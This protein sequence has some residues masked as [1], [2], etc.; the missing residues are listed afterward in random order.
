M[1]SVTTFRKISIDFFKGH[2]LSLIVAT[3]ITIALLSQINHHVLGSG[4][5]SIESAL[6]SM[7]SDWKTLISLFAFKFI[8][9]TI[10]YGSGISGGLFMP[11]LLLG[12]SL[13]GFIGSISHMIFPEFSPNIGAFALIGMGSFFASVIKAP[14]TSIIMVFELTRDYNIILPLMISNI[15][16]YALSLALDKNSIYESISEQDGIHLP[17][18]EDYEILDTF[19]VEEAM[20]RDVV[21]LQSSD[22]I[23]K[24]YAENKNNAISGFPVMSR[25]SLVGMVSI[26]EMGAALSKES[27]RDKTIGDICMKKIIKI[28]PDQSY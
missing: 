3:F 23:K 2:R 17:K 10:S 19:V 13:G 12:A 6:L 5:E 18:K 15:I 28:Y 4:H 22:A 1:K 7:F 25:N 11:T 8:A 16:S 14:F 26:N 27:L 21:F 24:S 20:V 9:T